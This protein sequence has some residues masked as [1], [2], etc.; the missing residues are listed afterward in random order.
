MKVADIIDPDIPFKVCYQ[1]T[2]GP[3]Q[4][5]KPNIINV[6]EDLAEEGI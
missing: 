6:L 5:I 1:S 2:F 4:W 3:E